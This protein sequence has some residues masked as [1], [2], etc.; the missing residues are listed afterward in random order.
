MPGYLSE[1]AAVLL[2]A[3][4]MDAAAPPT[5]DISLAASDMAGT[6]QLCGNARIDL[7]DTNPRGVENAKLVFRSDA[8]FEW[9]P[10]DAIGPERSEFGR[11]VTA[12]TGTRLIDAGGRDVGMLTIRSADERV[13]SRNGGGGVL[14]CRLGDVAAADRP[15]QPRS[16]AFYRSADFDDPDIAR[17][18]EVRRPAAGSLLGTWELAR[19]VVHDSAQAWFDANPYG[20]GNIRI[21]FD[22]RQFCFA[23]LQPTAH[24]VDRGCVPAPVRGLRVRADDDAGG[25][26]AP[27]IAGE[28]RITADGVMRVPR[29]LH[30]E[31]FVW[32]GPDDLTAAPLE[33]RI[34]LVTFPGENDPP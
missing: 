16:I 2:V 7:R 6:W 19:L 4:G 31:E 22:G 14:L 5:A 27:W 32:L 23:V 17:N 15:L 25:M 8:S 9:R 18:A 3:T 29:P 11:T 13:L 20:Q 21:A 26:L 24:D 34:T 10:A 12:A 28:V 30:D 1:L 33:G